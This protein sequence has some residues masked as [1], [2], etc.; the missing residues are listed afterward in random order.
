MKPNQS[1]K[2]KHGVSDA[3]RRAF[4]HKAAKVG[5]VTPVAVTMM[6]AAGSRQA[7]AGLLKYVCD[8]VEV[9]CVPCSTCTP[10]DVICKD[11]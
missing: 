11:W 3:E 4:L 6:L 8:K 1:A 2:P 7:H 5:A 9:N 10:C